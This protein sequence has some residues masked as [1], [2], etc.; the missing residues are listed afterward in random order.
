MSVHSRAVSLLLLA[1][2]RVAHGDSS[3]Q[4]HFR[5]ADTQTLRAV[6]G[7]KGH[8]YHEP[9]GSGNDGHLVADQGFWFSNFTVGASQNLELLVDTGSTSVIVNPG[10]YRP[11]PGG[12]I[13]GKPFQISYG[14]TN[15]DGTGDVT[16]NGTVYKDIV[17]QHGGG[18]KLVV[19]HQGLG[20]IRWPASPAPLPHDG[21]VGFCGSAESSAL[22]ET[23]FIHNLCDQGALSAC[24]FGL[25][26]HTNLTGDIYYG[27]LPTDLLAHDL[28]SA[29]IHREWTIRDALALTLDGKTIR[30]SVNISTDS[31]RAV[32]LGPTD[33]VTQLFEAAGVQVV[34]SGDGTVTTVTGYYD[35]R[36][37]PKIGF[38]L[39]GQTFD[40]V[41]AA[42]A[43]ARRGHNCTASVK[44]ASSLDNWWLI[45][46]PFFQGRYVDH[47]IQ[48]Q[49]MGFANLK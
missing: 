25:A 33:Q 21:I 9:V 1:V 44:G 32:V 10:L 23:P 39:A 35:C 48:A 24:R 38:S 19:R 28:V 46:Q 43:Y 45:G 14:T 7:L 22:G 4:L 6:A 47:D 18:A 41:P 29:P 16:A 36:A 30:P 3:H 13:T 20:D 12:I 34:R 40:I 26:L 49:R 8:H 2:L 5:K 15:S 42:L 37:P 31:G 11:S 27:A 17:S